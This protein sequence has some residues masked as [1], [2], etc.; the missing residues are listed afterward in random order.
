MNSSAAVALLIGVSLCGVPLWAS[1]EAGA[2]VA[3]RFSPFLPSHQLWSRRR[4]Q[5][6]QQRARVRKREREGAN[7]RS[8]LERS[9]LYAFWVLLFPTS[10]LPLPPQSHHHSRLRRRLR[11]GSRL[12]N[13]SQR[14]K[15]YRRQWHPSSSPFYLMLQI[16]VMVPSWPTVVVGTVLYA[17]TLRKGL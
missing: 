5:Q 4:A 14:S 16:M 15:C 13:G 10:F 1:P 8:S 2:H 7:L 3:N 6:Q 9:L 12:L 17:I 11:L